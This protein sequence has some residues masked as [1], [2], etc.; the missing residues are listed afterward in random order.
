MVKDDNLRLIAE[1]YKQL[2]PYKNPFPTAVC[3]VA[4]VLTVPVSSITYEHSF[5]KMKPIKICTRNTMSDTR[6]SDICRLCI[7]KDFEIDV[8]KVIDIFSSNHVDSRIL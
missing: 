2:I 4:R 1:F 7:E 8:D 3:M 6:L 5:S